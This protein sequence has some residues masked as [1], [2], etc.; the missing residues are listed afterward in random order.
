MQ[1]FEGPLDLLLHLIEKAELDIQD[2]PIAE[3][4]A[5]YLSYVDAMQEL[6]LDMASEFLVMAST[7]LAIKSKMLLPRPVDLM[8]D[9]SCEWE[10]EEEDPRM[11][12][13]ERLM[14]YKKY[15]ELAEELKQ[16]EE[17]RSQI[18][19][20]PPD[21]LAAFLPEEDPNPVEGVTLY[22][23]LDAFTRALAKV[24]EEEPQAAIQRDEISVKERMNEIREE[25][26]G[27]KGQLLFS[28]LLS[29]YR[30]RSEIIVTFLAILE[31]MKSGMVRCVQEQLFTDIRIQAVDG[32][33]GSGGLSKDQVDY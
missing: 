27:S 8:L 21:S 2:I 7:L 5:Q 32:E 30:S 6:Q 13:M 10:E 15:K 24:A 1:A 19:T 14:E 11:A 16:R 20:R 12:L 28:C 23:L 17:G 29:R 3:I 9:S 26:K 31:L 22:D 18:Y 4:T 33:G 25:L